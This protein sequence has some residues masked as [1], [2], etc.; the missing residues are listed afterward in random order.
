[1]IDVVV[2]DFST[3]N[4]GFSCVLLKVQVVRSPDSTVM[5]EIVLVAVSRVPVAAP[6]SLAHEALSVEP[7]PCVGG[8]GDGIVRAERCGEG[9]RVSAPRDCLRRVT[10][11]DGVGESRRRGI[12]AGCVLDD[13]QEACARV[14]DAVERIVVARRSPRT[15]TSTRSP[16]SESRLGIGRILVSENAGERQAGTTAGC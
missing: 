13:L 7:P 11:I 6:D 9:A 14:V 15:G 8:L 5:P 12:C 2:D 10:R 4:T 1:M 3:V 16:A